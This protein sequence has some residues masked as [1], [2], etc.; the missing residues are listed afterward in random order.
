MYLSKTIAIVLLVAC[1]MWAIDLIF[2]TPM[3]Q[4]IYLK[5]GKV[6]SDNWLVG[7]IEDLRGGSRDAAQ[8]WELKEQNLAK[9]LIHTTAAVALVYASFVGF[10]C[11]WKC[12]RPSL[13]RWFPTI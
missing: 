12:A 9:N 1:L 4:G 7:I 8:A 10:E 6:I 2:H 3:V 13:P 5:N 11:T